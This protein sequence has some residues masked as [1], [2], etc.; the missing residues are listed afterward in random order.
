MAELHEQTNRLWEENEQLR[1]R[2]EASRTEQL[3]EPPC[4]HLVSRPDKGKEVA[5]PDDI[6][7]LADDEL[8]SCS[9]PLPCRSPSPNP[10]EAQARK[11]PPRRSSRSISVARAEYEQNPEETSVSQRQ[12]I[13]MCLTGLEASPRY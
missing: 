4:P 1:T 3:R 6:D 10:A 9:S 8:Y 5:A 2:L 11:R 13:N 7:L 12:L